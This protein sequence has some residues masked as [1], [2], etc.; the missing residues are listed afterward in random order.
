MA[1]F[2]TYVPQSRGKN[3][4]CIVALKG[5]H[6]ISRARPSLQ[7]YAKLGYSR[8]S[9]LDGAGTQCD[10]RAFL[11]S[12]SVITSLTTNSQRRGYCDLVYG[13]SLH[14]KAFQFYSLDGSHVYDTGNV[15]GNL[16]FIQSIANVGSKK[17]ERLGFRGASF[18]K[19]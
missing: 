18:P 12:I 9:E 17:L 6:G 10:P 1:Q 13:L 15:E 5:H 19:L 4:H 11:I 2:P 3:D 16:L 7:K 8:R 14:W